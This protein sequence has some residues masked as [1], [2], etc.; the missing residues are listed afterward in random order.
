MDDIKIALGQDAKSITNT[1]ATKAG[2]GTLYKF[3]M[4]RCTLP[5]AEENCVFVCDCGKRYRSEYYCD[6]RESLWRWVGIV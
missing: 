5:T 4:H 6:M 2:T 3:T 1:E